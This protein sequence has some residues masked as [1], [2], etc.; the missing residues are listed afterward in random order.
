MA[1]SW[2]TPVYELQDQGVAI[3]LAIPKEGAVG[4]ADYNCISSGVTDPAR[5]R[6]AES[7]INYILGPDF[8]EVTG[9]PRMTLSRGEVI[10]DNG[11][12]LAEAGR[13]RLLKRRRF[14]ETGARIRA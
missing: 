7:F 1:Y 2:V 13:G 8:G 3:D 9:W 10:V 6:A 14:S 11:K 12:V 5:L 4:W